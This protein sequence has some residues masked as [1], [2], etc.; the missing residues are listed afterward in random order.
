MIDLNNILNPRHKDFFQS[1]NREVL[2]YGGAAGG[3]SYSAAD[4]I[5]LGMPTERVQLKG[6]VVRKSMPSIKRTCLDILQRRCKAFGIPYTLNRVDMLMEFPDL[7]NSQIYFVSVNN[8]AEIEKIKSITD[9]DFVWV[10]EA[11]E[12]LEAAYDQIKLRLRGGKASYKQIVLTFNPISTTSWI[13]HRF[14]ESSSIAQKIH[15]TV[16]DN[17]WADVQYVDDLRSLRHSNENL[18][19]V[20]YLGRWGSL[21]GTVYTNWSIVDDLPMDDRR[22]PVYDEVIYGADFGVNNQSALVKIYVSDGVPYLEEKLYQT[23]LTPSDIVDMY[24]TFEIGKNPIYADPSAAAYILELR[25]AGFIVRDAQNAVLDGI[26]YVKSLPVKILSNSPNL[27]KEYQ[28][29]SWERDSMGNWQ[30]RPV[31]F[32]DHLMDSVRYA[33]FSHRSRFQFAKIGPDGE[34]GQRPKALEH[35]SVGQMLQTMHRMKRYKL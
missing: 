20:Y 24:K 31:K 17:P 8:E 21:E 19:N 33:L 11:N 1:T 3:K 34:L 13:Y 16:E 14:F 22:E 6:L 9:V 10:E 29:Y 12:I 2:F 4:K 5:L 32:R 27:I 28:S 25:R 18:Y 23:H 15:V 30:D 26:N 7:F 35:V